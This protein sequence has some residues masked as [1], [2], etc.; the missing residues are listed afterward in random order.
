MK[1]LILKLI[2]NACYSEQLH[3]T[4]KLTQRRL[5]GFHLSS[6]VIVQLAPFIELV[7][8]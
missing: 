1:Y 7:L 4:L 6:F 8:G 2:L 5:T 3:V